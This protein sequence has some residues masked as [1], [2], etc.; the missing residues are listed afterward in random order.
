MSGQKVYQKLLT[1]YRKE[2]KRLRDEEEERFTKLMERALKKATLRDSDELVLDISDH[3]SGVEIVEYLRN[4][5]WPVVPKTKNEYTWIN[6]NK[7]LIYL[8]EPS[9]V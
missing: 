2:K 4:A 5:G 9:E 7:I 3:E 8:I 6:K 1:E